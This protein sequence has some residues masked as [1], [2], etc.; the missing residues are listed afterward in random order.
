MRTRGDKHGC[1][2]DILVSLFTRDAFIEAA[3]DSG[4]AC[5]DRLRPAREQLGTR[6]DA[7]RGSS[8]RAAGCGRAIPR[9]G[10]FRVGRDRLVNSVLGRAFSEGRS[11]T[12]SPYGGG[13]ALRCGALAAGLSNALVDVGAKTGEFFTN[14]RTVCR[15][16]VILVLVAGAARSSLALSTPILPTCP[17][18][19]I[20]PEF[21]SCG[22]R[23]GEAPSSALEQSAGTLMHA[24]AE[25]YAAGIRFDQP[26][27]PFLVDALFEQC[28]RPRG[29]RMTRAEAGREGRFWLGPPI[30]VPPLWRY[31]DGVVHRWSGVRRAIGAAR[32]RAAV[33]SP[34]F[35]RAP[36]MLGR[37]GNNRRIAPRCFSARLPREV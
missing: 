8:R 15:G 17:A 36:Y 21:G 32:R 2:R 28:H 7:P 33:T 3:D 27:S 25:P 26:Q 16:A 29:A 14:R 34:S 37:I 24:L 30:S 18:T 12:G 5:R 35:G 6:R 4:S 1:L 22:I 23:R 10:Q 13:A 11:M 20:R 9:E 31:P 19:G